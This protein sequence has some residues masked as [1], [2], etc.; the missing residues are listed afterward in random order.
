[1][2][3]SGKRLCSV[4]ERSLPSLSSALGALVGSGSR[5]SQLVTSEVQGQT[6]EE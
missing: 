6:A 4:S 2:E 3:V 1:M 5:G